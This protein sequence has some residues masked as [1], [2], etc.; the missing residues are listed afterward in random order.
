MRDLDALLRDEEKLKVWR[1]RLYAAL[2]PFIAEDETGAWRQLLGKCKA[3]GICRGVCSNIG[4]A[5]IFPEGFGLVADAAAGCL[6]TASQRALAAAGFNG[7]VYPY[8]DDF[9]NMKACYSPRG[10]A[11]LF[12][13][14]PLFISRIRPAVRPGAEISDPHGNRFFTAEAAGLYY[15][16]SRK[17]WSIT[18]RR[19]KLSTAGIRDFLID[20][21]FCKPDA[22]F[23][24]AVTGSYRDGTRLPDTGLFNF[25]AGLK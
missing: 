23:L 6:N 1:S 18:H 9:L 11:G 12:S 4:H 8:E 17:P 13:L 22:A 3:A 20:L 10:I 7:F 25:K 21:N 2:P 24:A 14:V 19:G 15:L 5:E 16:L